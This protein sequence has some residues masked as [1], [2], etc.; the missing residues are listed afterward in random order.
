MT[1]EEGVKERIDAS[2]RLLTLA[3]LAV[4]IMFFFL[5]WRLADSLLRPIKA[6]T[7]SAVAWRGSFAEVPPMAT[8]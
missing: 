5:A 4:V 6:M 1:V 2:Q 3:M 8:E 7:A